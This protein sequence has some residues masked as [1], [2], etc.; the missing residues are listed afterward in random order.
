MTRHLDDLAS[1]PDDDLIAAAVN[2]QDLHDHLLGVLIDNLRGRGRSYQSIGDALGF[3][4]HTAIRRHR[5]YLATSENHPDG[6]G[7][8]V[9]RKRIAAVA[10]A[11]A[12][13]QPD[14]P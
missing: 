9:A 11:L 3:S 7:G 6:D 13:Q 10:A 14:E 5:K 1:L 8:D 2:L 4:K 12:E